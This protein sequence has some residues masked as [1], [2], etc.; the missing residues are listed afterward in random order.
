MEFEKF[1]EIRD[2]LCLQEADVTEGKMMSSQSIHYKKKVFAFFSKKNKMVFKLGSPSAVE[3]IEVE[4]MEFN[5][6]K[7]KGPLKGW[8]EA[9]FQYH[10]SWE[11]LADIAL[12]KIKTD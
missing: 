10:E 2:K 6:F 3:G 1:L 8:Y 11:K 12:E 9:E 5:P 4:L 7:N